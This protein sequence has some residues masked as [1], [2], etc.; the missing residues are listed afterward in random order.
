MDKLINSLR[1]LGLS[2]VKYNLYKSGLAS[3]ENKMYDIKEN[4][5]DGAKKIIL[6]SIFGIICLF[7]LSM[8]IFFLLL[9]LFFYL[10]PILGFTVPSLICAGVC[11]IVTII[12]ILLVI[13]IK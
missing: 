8:A 1:N 2:Y 12:L 7:F 10:S 11:F 5:Q 6:M 13:I 4:I 3:V 9:T